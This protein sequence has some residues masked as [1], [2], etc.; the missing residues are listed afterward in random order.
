MTPEEERAAFLRRRRG[1]NI[2][3]FLALLALV[4]LF[5]LISVA[6]LARAAT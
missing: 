3:L 2:A 4:G 6:R 1:R 5:Y